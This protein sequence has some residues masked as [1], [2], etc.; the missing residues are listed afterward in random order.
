MGSLY[1]TVHAPPTSAA[2]PAPAG[3]GAQNNHDAEEEEEEEEEDE[4]EEDVDVLLTS[5]TRGRA[6]ALLLS[7]LCGPLRR[8]GRQGS[9]AARVVR[10]TRT[11]L[12]NADLHAKRDPFCVEFEVRTIPSSSS[13][14]LPSTKTSLR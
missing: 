13:L 1:A 8:N 7:L 14:C 2:A 3:A 4:E 5:G 10:L 6:E 11:F 12:L 9:T